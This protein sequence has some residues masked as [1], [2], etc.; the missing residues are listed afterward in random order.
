MS[1]V[2]VVRWV[3]K[4][5]DDSVPAAMMSTVMRVHMMNVRM[6][7]GRRIGW[8]VGRSVGRSIGGSGVHRS[9]IHRSGLHHMSVM[10][11]SCVMVYILVDDG[12]WSAVT[13]ML[14]VVMIVVRH[15]ENSACF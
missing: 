13:V 2:M 3:K 10:V 1:A 9:A 12:R 4:V 15:L 11:D 14:V 7:R 8:S 6:D 5:V